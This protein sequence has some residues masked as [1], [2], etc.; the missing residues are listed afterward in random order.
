[1]SI[2]GKRAL[3][4]IALLLIVAGA[5]PLVQADYREEIVKTFPLRSGGSFSLS[6]VNGNVTISTWA[7]DKAEVRALKVA[8]KSE[9][10]LA[11]VQVEFDATADAVA[12]KTVWPKVRRNLQV[13]VSFNVR[14][15]AGVRLADVETTN[16]SLDLRGEFS[17]AHLGTTNGNVVLEGCRGDLRATTTNGTV[18]VDGAEGRIEVGSTNGNIKIRNALPK[19]GLDAKTTNGSITLHLAAPEKVNADLIARTTNGH[20]ETDIPVTLERLSRSRRSLEAKIGA[21]GPAIR[22]STTN[23]SIQIRR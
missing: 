17:T 8:K 23:G 6:N 15:P 21:G 10:D 13:S 2:P 20:I 1:M 22:L 19:D 14:L 12:V 9:T 16:G 11:E 5:T 18:E 4:P 7:E 3:I